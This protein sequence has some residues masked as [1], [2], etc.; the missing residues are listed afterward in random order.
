[1]ALS[2]AEQLQR[3]GIP[4]EQAKLLGEAVAPPVTSVNGSTGAVVLDA[5][6]VG[7]VAVPDTPPAYSEVPEDLA[8]ALVAAGLMA[9]DA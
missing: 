8:A 2:L 9:P 4:G 3:V 7:A 6:D 1:M 5:T